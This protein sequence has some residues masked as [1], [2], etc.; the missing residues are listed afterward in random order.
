MSNRRLR[1]KALS[2]RT[3]EPC[4]KWAMSGQEVCDAH[5][6]RS[7]QAKAAAARRIAEQR[8]TRALERSGARQV[9]NPLEELQQLAAEIV[10]LKD[11]LGDRVVVL[12]QLRYQA[13]AGEQIRGELVAYERALDRSVRVLAE[14]ARLNI[15]ERLA[16][17]EESQAARLADQLVAVLGQ[18]VGL[19]FPGAAEGPARALL[20]DLFAVVSFD[21]AGQRL[22]VGDLPEAA[23]S[24]AAELRATWD[25]AARVPGLERELEASRAEVVRL[26]AELEAER[27]RK[28]VRVLPA[29]PVRPALPRGGG[30]HVVIDV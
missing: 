17:I 1:C 6:G 2:S 24:R 21:G 20:G 14:I 4:R 3:R 10:T 26:R 13:G 5:G 9:A 23:R 29:S 22:E 15:D 18:A 28:P 30:S 12:Q 27:E 7:P 19:V 16:R 11:W 25:A 8:A